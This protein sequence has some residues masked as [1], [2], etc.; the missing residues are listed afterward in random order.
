MTVSKRG[1]ETKD[2]E[3]V[4]LP[5]CW[6]CEHLSISWDPQFPYACGGMGFKSR[7]MPS[8]EVFRTS[9]ERCLAFRQKG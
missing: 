3:R 9:K 5:N 1:A 6:E 2:C 4:N 7:L 8:L